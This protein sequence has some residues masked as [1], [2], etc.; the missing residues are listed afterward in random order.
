MYD[1]FRIKTMLHLDSSYFFESVNNLNPCPFVLNFK[2]PKKMKKNRSSRKAFGLLS[3]F[4]V[5]SLLVSFSFIWIHPF[6]CSLLTQ[7]HIEDAN[8]PHYFSKSIISTED[9]RFFLHCGIDPIAIFR[10]TFINLKNRRFAQGGSTITQQLAKN[11]YLTHEKTLS[12]K[13]KEAGL[14]LLLEIQYDKKEILKEY[15]DIIYFGNHCYGI[16]AAADFYFHLSPSELSLSQAALLAGI[17]QSPNR[18]AP[19]KN[20]DLAKKRQVTVLER[21][22]KNKLITPLSFKMALREPLVLNCNV[23]HASGEFLKA[24][25]DAEHMFDFREHMCYPYPMEEDGHGDF[26]KIKNSC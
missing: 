25:P 5:L 22:L 18:L 6:C 3:S 1:F 10:A 2:M 21:M 19:N 20:F 24:N 9:K 4:L 17:P 14:S 15:M 26:R 8:L 23:F 7:T 12:R 13:L 16:D 11:K